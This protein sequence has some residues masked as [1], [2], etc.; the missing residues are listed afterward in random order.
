MK[1]ILAALA[2]IALSPAFAES[3]QPAEVGLIDSTGRGFT[4][5]Q[6]FVGKLDN[7]V[8]LNAW[9]VFDL[10][11]LP[12][13]AR[14]FTIAFN[15]ESLDKKSTYELV[16]SDVTT[17]RAILGSSNAGLASFDDLQSGVAYGSVK[18]VSGR[19]EVALPSSLSSGAIGPAFVVGISNVT[20]RTQVIESVFD[21]GS[22]ITSV[23]LNY[24]ASPV[25]ESHGLLYAI[26]G[27]GCLS[28]RKR[29]KPNPFEADRRTGRLSATFGLTED[30]R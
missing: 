26:L 3:V 27:V 20:T 10:S 18:A 13:D 5:K 8:E 1:R 15:T 14:D 17:P 16:L 30:V 22:Y 24:S 9:F 11:A 28:L 2:V 23:S 25:P 4:V 21:Y 7:N 12:V 6:P 19:Y 29:R